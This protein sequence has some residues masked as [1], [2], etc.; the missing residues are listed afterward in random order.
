VTGVQTCALPILSKNTDVLLA[1]PGAGSKLSKARSLGLKIIDEM[2][3]V[4]I[5]SEAGV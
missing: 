4:E 5:V 3:F 1:G 2:E